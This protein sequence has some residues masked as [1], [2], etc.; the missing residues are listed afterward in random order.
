MKP[1]PAPAQSD[2]GDL[3]RAE[4]ATILNPAHELF[5]LADLIDWDQVEAKV[6]S[7]YADE[8]RPGC[9][10][11]LM[12]GLHYLKYT[13]DQSDEAVCERWVENPYW[14]YFCGERYL[15]HELPIDPSSLSRW[16]TRM[17]KQ[18]FNELLQLTLNLA[19]GTGLTKRSDFREVVVDTT[20]QEK[21]IAH[22]TD[23]KLYDRG[24]RKLVKLAQSRGLK[25]RQTYARTGPA[26]LRQHGRYCHAKQFR[27]AR[28]VRRRLRNYFGRVLRDLEKKAK[29]A[30]GDWSDNELELIARCQWV[31]DQKPGDKNKL[32]SLHEPAVQCI[33]KGKAHK[34]YE[35]GSKVAVVSS[36]KGN[37]IT[38]S[39]SL[40]GNPYDGHTL[41]ESVSHSTL[42]TGRMPK[43]AFV[44]KGYR[45]HDIQDWPIE[46][47]MPGQ[48]RPKLSRWMR[49]KLKRRTAV[50]PL[51]GHEKS[52]HRLGRCF[53]K[54][55]LGDEIN[56]TS[57]AMGFNLRKVLRG[58]A[59]LAC[60]GGMGGLA[61]AWIGRF[62]E[63]RGYGQGS[64]AA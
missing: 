8:G 30:G 48:K 41:A 33:S 24:R 1:R 56:A 29:V 11:R 47:V 39:V 62:C 40:E 44:D 53:L 19:V 9:S 12:V 35:F 45:G 60:A 49:R 22:P 51:I 10:G 28:K 46:A 21:N 13:F 36:L 31:Y 25:L 34:R 54:G 58:L 42:N 63:S 61:A 37:W 20:V 5:R 27:R 3:F 14:Q 43:R 16:R 15:Q 50:E 38:A 26:D 64:L 18:F 2:P 23:P 52:D 6:A 7:K 57:A 55:V 4:L 17:G 32:Y 59:A